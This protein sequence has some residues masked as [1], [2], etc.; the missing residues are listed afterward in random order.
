MRFLKS[1][2]FG[3]VIVIILSLP[4]TAG[5]DPP[6]DNSLSPPIIGDTIYDCA[7]IISYHGADR[8]SKIWVYVNGSKVKE[9]DSF[10]GR[11]V[12]R[13]SSPLSTGDVVSAA[14]IVNNKRSAKSR[15]PVTVKSIPMGLLDHG[16]K[17]KNP[18]EIIPPLYECQRVVLIRKVI[19]G[20][21]VTL[22]NVDSDTWK[23]TTPYTILRQG[24]PE[25]KAGQWYNAM[26]DLCDSKIQPSD[27]SPK[28]T[29]QAKPSSLPAT[30][31]REPVPAG[32]DCCVV[33][34]LVVGAKV[35]IY[36]DN[37]SGVVRV[38]GGH[39]VAES[40]LF[41]IS[42]SFKS[43]SEYYAKQA[44]CEVESPKPDDPTKPSPTIPVPTVK[45]PICN[46]EYY[47]TV[48]GTA[49]GATVKVYSNGTQVAQ[50][51]GNGGCLKMALGDNTKFSTGQKVTA[52]QF[53]AGTGSSA[54]AAVTVSATGS[55]D[56]TPA[57][58]NDSFHIVRNN[59]YAYA[60]DILCGPT[61]TAKQQPGKAS[62]DYPNP[63]TCTDIGNAAV[64]DGLTST[65]EKQCG[66]C[67]HLAA[68]VI[69][70]ED[71]SKPIPEVADYHWYRLD[72]NGRWSHKPGWTPATDRDAD[73]SLI[74]NVE[75]ANRRYQY[76]SATGQDYV[77]DYKTFCSY[78]CVDK[79]VVVI[80]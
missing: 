58:W 63:I 53:V 76:T 73:G 30:T 57:M 14:Q 50:A 46:G 80:K 34:G 29:V 27:W 12:I 62:G 33:D 10:W 9:V 31:I 66:D 26:M 79:D 45:G 74:P 69:A 59:C 72:S 2:W 71:L 39:A 22:R 48:C 49:V 43:T 42:P 37:G 17:I 56:Y 1:W 67:T 15:D 65:S 61:G 25:L 70:H 64:S 54:S 5:C 44:L 77:L 6:L 13:L 68:L 23:N 20:A 11:G 55:P 19:Q 75:T 24:T 3:I 35:D 38:G 60:C 52:L 41:R 28:V 36:E 21:K 40:T 32:S 18:P 47:V 51:A 8:E 4:F 7:E 16:E 78:Y